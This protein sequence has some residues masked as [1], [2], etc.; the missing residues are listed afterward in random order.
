MQGYGKFAK[1]PTPQLSTINWPTLI[2]Q[3]K[4]QW[5]VEVSLDERV[6]TDADHTQLEQ[7]LINL[8]KNA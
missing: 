5:Q 7:L 6:T 1:L 2:E 8:L 4:S 3:L